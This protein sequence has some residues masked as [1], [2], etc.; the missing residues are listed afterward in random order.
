MGRRKAWAE[1][2]ACELCGNT[3]MPEYSNQVY[4]CRSHADIA[5][6]AKGSMRGRRMLE[7]D[8]YQ[9]MEWYD[10]GEYHD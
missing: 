7:E 8:P 5:H 2:R 10:R 3:Y 4:C 1:L 6:R 9:A